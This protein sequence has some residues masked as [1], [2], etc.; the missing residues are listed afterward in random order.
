KVETTMVGWSSLKH[1]NLPHGQQH[2]DHRRIHLPQLRNGLYRD[3]RGA[4]AQAF[5]QF[6]M[7]CLCCR[8]PRLVWPSS[9]LRLEGRSDADACLREEMGS[10]AAVGRSRAARPTRRVVLPS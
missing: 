9:F 3:E 8:G 7:Q 10:I 5:R 4:F 6:Q 1:M 2:L